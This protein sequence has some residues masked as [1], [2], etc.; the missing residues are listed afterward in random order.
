MRVQT[1][2]WVAGCAAAVSVALLAGT[3]LLAYVD[4]HRLP[5]DVTIWNFSD[6]LDGVSNLAVPVVGFV[7]AS[8][9]PANRVGWVF[10]AAGLGLGLGSFG[11]AYGLHAL[12]AAPGSWPAGRAAAWLANWI[13]VIP[14]AMLAFLFLLF[15]AGKLRSRR[16]RPAA[17]F[18]GGAFTFISVYMLV[19][20]A[21]SWSHPFGFPGA[22]TGNLLVLLITIILLVAALVVSVV[23][24]VMR[25]ARS[26]GEERLQLKWFAAAALLVVIT[27]IPSFLTTWV[28]AAV[29]SSV[30]F[31]C[32]YAAIAIAVLKYRL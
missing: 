10:L 23:A 28:A 20:A 29:L 26:S 21:R 1:T 25:F 14:I 19:S 18:V 17:W 4:R 13:W 22:Q 8:R 12:V 9:R 27:F 31:L 6:V 11:R 5:A 16:W 32:L 7:I 30:A 2:R 24:V 15:P 3:F